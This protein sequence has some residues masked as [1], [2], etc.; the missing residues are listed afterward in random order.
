[1]VDMWKWR[2]CGNGGF[3][4]FHEA[5]GSHFHLIEIQRSRGN[6]HF[7]ISRVNFAD[8]WTSTGGSGSRL[9]RA[10]VVGRGGLEIL[11]RRT[12]VPL[13]PVQFRNASSRNCLRAPSLRF[14]PGASRHVPR[15]LGPKLGPWHQ[16]VRI[17]YTALTFLHGPAARIA[18]LGCDQSC[19]R[20]GRRG[21]WQLVPDAAHS[22]AR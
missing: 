9:R 14:H 3:S 16:A 12:P 21:A 2:T 10:R 19:G 15:R 22:D 6:R 5:A 1:M 11:W 8:R 17:T 13:Q 18:L 7:Q 4:D 20:R